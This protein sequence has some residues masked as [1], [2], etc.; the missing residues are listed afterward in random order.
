MKAKQNNI[1]MKQVL[2]P[3]I[4]V[5]NEAL[6]ESRLIKCFLNLHTHICREPL[7]TYT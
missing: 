1:I 2:K 7:S 6:Q 3:I 5:Y 4:L